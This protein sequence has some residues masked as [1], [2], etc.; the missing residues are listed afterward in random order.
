MNTTEPKQSASTMEGNELG[1][2][3]Y[4]QWMEQKEFLNALPGRLDDI[5]ASIDLLHQ[6]TEALG[7]RLDSKLDFILEEFQSDLNFHWSKMRETIENLSPS[8]GNI[9][10]IVQDL[11]M[12]SK[13]TN[14]GN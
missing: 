5:E 7:E 10:S 9:E 6:Y 11:E 8:I 4:V 14:Q 1:A 2:K 12:N 13:T 3:A